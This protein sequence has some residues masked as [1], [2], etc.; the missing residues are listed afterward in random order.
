M[1]SHVPTALERANRGQF[2]H[3]EHYAREK[4]TEAST[5]RSITGIADEAERAPEACPHIPRPAPPTLHSG[6]SPRR[7]EALSTLWAQAQRVPYLHKATGRMRV[8]KLRKDQP[9]ALVGVVSVP[10]E[11]PD[12]RWPEYIQ[13]TITWLRSK[14]GTRLTSVIEH[15]DE[16]NRHLHF[17]VVPKLG[18][19][20]SAVHQGLK[21]KED[22]PANS[23]RSYR[24]KAF[25]IAMSK[26]QDE[27]F[28][29]VS[30]EF[31]LLRLS[32]GG[33]RLNA[34]EFGLLKAKL[35]GSALETEPLLVQASAREAAL[36]LKLQQLERRN[37]ELE[38]RLFKFEALAEAKA[39]E[40]AMNYVIQ[41]A[42]SH[43]GVK[44]HTGV[45]AAPGQLS[46][47]AERQATARTPTPI[48]PARAPKR[49][50]M[51]A[52]ATALGTAATATTARAPAPQA[53]RP[54]TPFDDM[55]RPMTP[56]PR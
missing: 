35:A 23:T 10:P 16:P 9:C 52:P 50:P 43:A 33:K 42:R 38:H 36:K 49:M 3:V 54:P 18:E 56:R 44:P 27:F 7:A 2:I 46:Q 19:K 51:P 45:P 55:R 37:N 39:A 5:R 41:A 20:F 1:E 21:A 28:E 47:H 30:G 8:R 34:Q 40:S 12:S 4:S 53:P 17:W 15:T 14:Y 11:F 6:A 48:E 31:G 13:K 29:A 32:V 25:S 26:Y 24:R 22:A